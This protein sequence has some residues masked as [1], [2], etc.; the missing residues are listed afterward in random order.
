MIRFT[1][2]MRDI[3]ERTGLERSTVSRILGGDFGAHR[4]R[5]ETIARVRREAERLGYQPNRAARSLKTGRSNLVGV[6][7]ARIRNPWFGELAAELVAAL[8]DRG[9]R[10]IMADSNEVFLR[11]RD[12]LRDL[13]AFG[14]DGI[15]FS[16][17]QLRRQPAMAALRLPVVVLDYRLYP[18]RPC[19][20]LDYPAAA[21]EMLALARARGRRRVGLVCH[22]ATAEAERAFLAASTGVA[23]IRPPAAARTLESVPEQV[24]ILLERKADCLIGLNNDLTIGLLAALRAGG[25]RARRD[26]GVAGIDDFP[27]AALLEPALTVLRQ[28]VPAYAKAAVSLLMERIENPGM[29]PKDVCCLGELVVRESV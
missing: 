19:V 27:A 18:E 10:V 21:R 24:R 6:L 22:R 12:S 20:R 28:P 17:C 16:P 11:E 14:V 15:I 3:S 25:G 1:P 9:C 7:T 4:Y 26:V 29:K 5:P 13:V 2:T 8:S 23:V